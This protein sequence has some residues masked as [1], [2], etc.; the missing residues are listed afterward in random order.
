MSTRNGVLRDLRTT[1]AAGP[2]RASL[3]S[4]P[5]PDRVDLEISEVDAGALPPTHNGFQINAAGE[6]IEING[7]RVEF[8]GLTAVGGATFA[9]GAKVTAHRMANGF[10]RIAAG[11]GGSSGGSSGSILP[12]SHMGGADGPVI[13]MTGT[14]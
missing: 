11:G 5:I 7:N 8:V 3:A 1:Q 9:V 2:G 4:S 12:H 13:S 14:L 6:A 10:W